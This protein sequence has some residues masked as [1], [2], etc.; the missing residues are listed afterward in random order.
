MSDEQTSEVVVV[1]QP[2]GIV[3]A[4][5]GDVVEAFGEYQRIQAGLDHAIPDGTIT[6]RGKLYRKKSYWRAVKTAFNVQCECVGERREVI[7]GDWGYLVTYRATA[8]N[9]CLADGDGACFASEKKR[10]QDTIHNVRS[11]A[12]TRAFN[13]AVSNLVGF[14]EVS[15]EEVNERGALP[16]PREPKR[17]PEVEW[18]SPEERQRLVERSNALADQMLDECMKSGAP[19]VYATASEL[20]GALR[21]FAVESVGLEYGKLW[22]ADRTADI[23][24]ALHCSQLDEKGRPVLVDPKAPF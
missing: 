14:G 4:A 17:E 18:V 8:P 10:G 21:K 13:R 15:A 7:D 16:P 22:P 24:H 1:E 12:H 2:A 19:C 9:G 3:R 23:E 20:A 11:H 6:I 5:P